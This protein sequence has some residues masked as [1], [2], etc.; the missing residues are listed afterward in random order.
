[1]VVPRGT[2]SKRTDANTLHLPRLLLSEL[3]PQ[4]GPTRPQETPKPSQAGLLSLGWGRCSFAL[5]AGCTRC[6]GALQESLFSPVLW[7]LCNQ[8]P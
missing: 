3:R 5:G 8:V 4:G 2:S 7:K 1:M 6:A